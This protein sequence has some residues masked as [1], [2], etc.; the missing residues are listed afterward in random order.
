[1]HNSSRQHPYKRNTL[2][3]D[4]LRCR[5]LSAGVVVHDVNNLQYEVSHK[6]STTNKEVRKDVVY[7][8][9]KPSPRIDDFS[10]LKDIKISTSEDDYLNNVLDTVTGLNN[11]KDKLSTIKS[12]AKQLDIFYNVKHPKILNRASIKLLNLNCTFENIIFNTIKNSKGGC[13]YAD[14]CSAPGGFTF[15][16]QKVTQRYRK[17]V[18]SYMFT[19]YETGT[20]LKVDDKLKHMHNVDITYGD[21]YKKN[22]RDLYIDKVKTVD[23]VLADGGIDFKNI[24]NHQEFYSKNLYVSQ[25]LLCLQILKPGGFMI[26]KFFDL[27]LK[28]SSSLLFVTTLVFEEV[29][30]CKAISTKA[31]NSERYIVFKNYKPN[32][33]ITEILKDVNDKLNKNYNISSFIKEDFP[34]YMDFKKKLLFINKTLAS[35]QIVALQMYTGAIDIPDIL[36]INGYVQC[37]EWFKSITI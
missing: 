21:I 36:K 4:N 17:P 34:G 30:I 16:I 9:T 11:E 6:I 22:D 8:L 20:F 28:F 25:V 10:T 5:L 13:S 31:G 27:F 12:K 1:M 37:K 35:A 18:K 15:F 32:N 19:M 3:A 26:C 14:L 33:D 7:T 23:F 24:E 2:K 29:Q